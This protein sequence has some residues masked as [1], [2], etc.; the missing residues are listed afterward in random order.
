MLA[1]FAQIA[2][3]GLALN[4]LAETRR[5]VLGA[6]FEGVPISDHDAASIDDR[7]DGP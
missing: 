5:E 2:G 3:A 1:V 7:L 4:E 6:L